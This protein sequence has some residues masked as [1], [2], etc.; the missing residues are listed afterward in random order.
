[1]RHQEHSSLEAIE[2]MDE[3]VDCLN[4]EVVCRLVEQQQVWP[5]PRDIRKY[6]AAALPA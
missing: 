4:V 2:S 1:M 5:L 6:Y 3:R